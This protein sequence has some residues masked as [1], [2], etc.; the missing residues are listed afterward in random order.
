MLLLRRFSEAGDHAAF[1]EIIRRYAGVV[2]A[3]C[4]RIVRD[5]AR[6]EDVSQETF[7]RLMRRPDAVSQSLGAWL[8]TAATNLAVDAVRSDSAR[9]RREQEYA[10][11]LARE[12]EQPAEVTSW[13]ELSPHID[14]AL[15]ELPDEFREILVAHFLQGRPQNELAA[16][17]KISAATM[18]RRIR[19]AIE[20]LQDNLRGKGL[21]LA[22]LALIGLM[23]DNALQAV[24]VSL[25]AGLG[26][27]TMISGAKG[28]LQG[29]PAM[30]P[31]SVF[32][33]AVGIIGASLA[34]GAIIACFAPR[35]SSNHPATGSAEITPMKVDF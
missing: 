32:W 11:D 4:Q 12:Q 9:H 2:F 21:T 10:Q 19:S 30:A 6:A 20:A 33:L 25:T 15:A 35:H 3:A 8:H 29:A 24:P 7:F 34:L 13:S 16:E 26:K 17:A 28:L 23:H 22:P 5:P 27:M 18:S 14:A 31:P 1:A